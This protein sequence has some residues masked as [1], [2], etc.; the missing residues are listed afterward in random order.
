MW[1]SRF[2]S[3]SRV[4]GH[5]GLALTLLSSFPPLVGRGGAVFGAKLSDLRSTRNGSRR[6]SLRCGRVGVVMYPS[7]IPFSAHLSDSRQGR[8]PN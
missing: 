1:P 2:S 4:G 7:G 5:G 3:F 6:L 8:S